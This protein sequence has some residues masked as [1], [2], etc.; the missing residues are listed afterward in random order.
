[1]GKE[2]EK[3]NEREKLDAT[4]SEIHNLN[5]CTRSR[6]LVCIPGQ[7]HPK[8]LTNSSIGIHLFSAA[9]VEE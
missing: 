1:M 9:D 8:P 2:W 4:L 5:A 7:P 3:K 6:M